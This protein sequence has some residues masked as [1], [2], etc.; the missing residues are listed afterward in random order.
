[1][2]LAEIRHVHGLADETVP[3]AGR[4]L[5]VATQ[6]DTRRSFALLRRFAGCGNGLEG[7]AVA[8]ELTC[9][10]QAC[11]GARQ[12]LCLHEGGH[13]VKPAWIERAWREIA[14]ARGW[15]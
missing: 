3:L 10:A 8:G 5:S 6:G 15:S 11:G 2:P 9:A 7:A 1:M 12:E 4:K 13:S 14:R